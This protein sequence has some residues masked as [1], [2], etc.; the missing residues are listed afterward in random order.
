VLPETW[1]SINE[2]KLIGLSNNTVMIAAKDFDKT[3]MENVE[4]E[5]VAKLYSQGPYIAKALLRFSTLELAT[6]VDVKN[7]LLQIKNE[8]QKQELMDCMTTTTGGP[9]SLS[10][11]KSRVSPS[12]RYAGI[13]AVK[14]SLLQAVGMSEEEFFALKSGCTQ[15]HSFC[16]WHKVFLQRDKGRKNAEEVGEQTVLD[17]PRAAKVFDVVRNHLFLNSN[18]LNKTARKINSADSDRKPAALV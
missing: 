1:F 10:D 15:A 16:H 17:A 12:V 3:L 7:D 9:G 8:K 4:P 6:H 18:N 14:A 5:I 2:R 11:A 13:L